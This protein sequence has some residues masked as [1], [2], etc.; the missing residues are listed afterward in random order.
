VQLFGNFTDEKPA[1]YGSA[2]A[3]EA[4]RLGRLLIE[5]LP[6][7]EAVGLLPLM[8]LHES[9]RAARTSPAGDLVLL[10]DQDRSLPGTGIR[11]RR[12]RTW[13]NGHYCR[14]GSTTCWPGRI[15]RPWSS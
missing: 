5:L 6:E 3:G 14:A 10:D 9:R 13:W 2:R 15:R 12:E 4:I 7:P 1:L 8:L 11:L